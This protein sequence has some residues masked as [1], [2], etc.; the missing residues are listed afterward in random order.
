MTIL[1]IFITS[2]V[3]NELVFVKELLVTSLIL[4]GTSEVLFIKTHNHF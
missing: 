2:S 3:V 4:I 1:L